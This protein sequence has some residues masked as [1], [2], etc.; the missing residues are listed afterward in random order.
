MAGCRLILDPGVCG[1][2]CEV[3]ASEEGRHRVR[4]RI[5]SKCA[6]IS[7]LSEFL[8]VLD[9]Q[10]IFVP[11]NRN[12]IFLLSEKAGCHAS[13]PVPV[14]ILKCAEV[15]MGLALPRGVTFHFE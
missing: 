4:I 6:Q 5:K 10:E 11:P 2:Q 9:L 15:A 3:E 13:C 1:F 12:R 7:K 8:D 14:G